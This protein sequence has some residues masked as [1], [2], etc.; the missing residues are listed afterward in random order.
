MIKNS[1]KI[2]DESIQKLRGSSHK[3]DFML[4]SEIENNIFHQSD[5][6]VKKSQES[7]EEYKAYILE[8]K[9]S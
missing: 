8:F 1:L 9:W 7:K 3:I 4:S 5:T 6:I 2:S